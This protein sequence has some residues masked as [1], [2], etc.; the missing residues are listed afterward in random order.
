M[1]T[2]MDSG[3]LKSHVGRTASLSEIGDV[4]DDLEAARYVG[5]AV[6]TDFEHD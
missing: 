5:R 2:R 3:R 1:Y 4:F 6:I